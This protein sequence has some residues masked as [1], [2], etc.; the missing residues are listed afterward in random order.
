M[1]K[2][3][4]RFCRI[5]YGL[6]CHVKILVNTCWA[7]MWK[8]G[9][10]LKTPSK[11]PFF[12]VVD[13]MM[14]LFDNM[15]SVCMIS[16]LKYFQGMYFHPNQTNIIISWKFMKFFFRK[17]GIFSFFSYFYTSFYVYFFTLKVLKKHTVKIYLVFVCLK[18]ILSLLEQQKTRSIQNLLL[19]Q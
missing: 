1:N 11:T 8:F 12:D 9:L 19:R 15:G 16:S 13:K 2:W 14:G 17:F 7:S 5:K 6:S 3:E 4:L 10:K 18:S